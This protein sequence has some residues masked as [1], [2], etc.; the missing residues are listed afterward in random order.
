MK[1]TRW[2][3]FAKIFSASHWLTITKTLSYIRDR[4]LNMLLYNYKISLSNFLEPLMKLFLIKSNKVK[5]KVAQR[6][7]SF[8]KKTRLAV[9]NMHSKLLNNHSVHPLLS[10][11]GRG[12]EPPTNFS[13]RGRGVGRTSNF[14]GPGFRTFTPAFCSVGCALLL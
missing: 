5:Y 7:L 9:M 4:V 12:V 13:K 11:G 1:Y 2:R 3:F 14:R 8:K 6:V 10:A